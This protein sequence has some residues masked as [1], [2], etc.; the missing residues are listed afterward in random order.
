MYY[1]YT[2]YRE[3]IYSINR[4]AINTIPNIIPHRKMV[5]CKKLLKIKG[6]KYGYYKH[7]KKLYRYIK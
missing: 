2:W 5:Y 1:Y 3:P 7:Y 4:A 6:N